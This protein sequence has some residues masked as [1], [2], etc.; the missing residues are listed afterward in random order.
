MYFCTQS[1]TSIFSS[2]FTRCVRYFCRNHICFSFTLTDLSLSSLLP[3]SLS[4]VDPALEKAS[5]SSS[6]SLS[7]SLLL[8]SLK[9]EVLSEMGWIALYRA[10][11]MMKSRRDKK[12][13]IGSLCMVGMLC[14][15]MVLQNY[16]VLDDAKKNPSR[17][18]LSSSV[19]GNCDT[20]FDQVG[21]G[22]VAV[23]VYFLIILY[24]FC[25][26]AIICDEYFMASLEVWYWAY[27]KACTCLFSGPS[28]HSMPYFF[29]PCLSS[30]FSPLST[31][32]THLLLN[33]STTS[34]TFVVNLFINRQSRRHY[35]CQMM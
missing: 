22:S 10:R 12:L 3:L 17:R 13:L 1:C 8:K 33:W 2:F 15:C 20:H 19:G 18:Q 14:L 5:F 32:L 6:L 7:L 35:S 23:I 26:L 9:D 4:L 27:Q 30:L 21:K 25:G 31:C 29:V 24:A 16:G 34:H 28:H 11:T